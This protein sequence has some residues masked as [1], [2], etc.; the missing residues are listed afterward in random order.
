MPRNATKG[1]CPRTILQLQYSKEWT[2]VHGNLGRFKWCKGNLA[3]NG[4]CVGNLL[5][6]KKKAFLKRMLHD[7]LWIHDVLFFPMLQDT[8]NS[9]MTIYYEWRDEYSIMSN[10][11]MEYDPMR[12][13]DLLGPVDAK[14][15]D[16][17]IG[18]S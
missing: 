1:D 6:S 13:N 14:S 5:T 11:R 17:F 16:T 9:T 8:S 18:K 2:L 7:N 4:N 12:E 10:V 3:R 15:L